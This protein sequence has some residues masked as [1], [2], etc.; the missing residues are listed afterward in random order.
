MKSVEEIA[1]IKMV[2]SV[3]YLGVHIELKKHKVITSVNQITSSAY[4]IINAADC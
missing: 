4:F 2:D 1:G 3:K